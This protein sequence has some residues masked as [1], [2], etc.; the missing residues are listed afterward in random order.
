M[1][2]VREQHTV[3]MIMRDL[4]WPEGYF[5]PFHLHKNIEIIQATS[6]SF[7]AFIDGTWMEALPG[8]IIVI[9]ANTIHRFETQ[10]PVYGHLW[11][12][13]PKLL[14]NSD[15]CLKPVKNRITAEE[16]SS[17]TLFSEQLSHLYRL[18]QSGHRILSDDKNP[19]MQ[20][21]FS[22]F[23]FGL[24]TKFPGGEAEQSPS[25]EKQIFYEIAEYINLR[26]T[27]NITVQSIARDMF[28]SR[29]RISSIFEKYAGTDIN[30]YKNSLRVNK[31]NELFE[32]G[33][34]DITEVAYQSGFQTIRTFNNTYKKIMGITPS[35]Y[36]K[37]TV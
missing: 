33:M 24:M 11:Q 23:Y 25:D 10:N 6:S 36:I 21:I 13:N 29:G 20:S 9:D 27:E 16:I 31:A 15:I 12:I 8:D 7:R 17:D 34:A 37:K 5:S 19:F 22:A 2:I 26:F 28:V 32:S 3:D 30:A 1:E 35:E 4:Q 18:M 14:I